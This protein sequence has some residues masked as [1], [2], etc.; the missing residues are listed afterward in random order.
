MERADS[1]TRIH[2][3]HGIAVINNFGVN[4]MNKGD[5]EEAAT[6]FRTALSAMKAIDEETDMKPIDSMIVHKNQNVQVQQ[7]HDTIIFD[8]F[9]TKIVDVSLN[10]AQSVNR[11]DIPDLVNPGI[12]PVRINTQDFEFFDVSATDLMCSIIMYN[13]AATHLL[14]SCHNITEPSTLLL[15]TRACQDIL[16]LAL[17]IIDLQHSSTEK[18]LSKHLVSLLISGLIHSTMSVIFTKLGEVESSMWTQ[19]RCQALINKFHDFAKWEQ[20]LFGQDLDATN[21]AAAA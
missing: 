14:A 16:E 6:T 10:E 7:N 3:T 20:L 15:K 21:A 4:Q 1:Y 9:L 5:F 18:D 8:T 19:Q 11:M 17:Q 2:F 13:M 12:F